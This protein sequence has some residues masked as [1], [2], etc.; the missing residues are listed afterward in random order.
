ML[1]SWVDMFYVSRV[2]TTAVAAVGVSEQIMFFTFSFCLGFAF[3]TSILVARRFGEGN[4]DAAD[5]AATQG[6]VIMFIF[7]TFIAI[8]LYFIYPFLL[9]LMNITGETKR[10]AGIYLSVMVFGL[11]FN[12]L[13]FQMNA[14]VRSIGNSVYPMAI[15]ILSN[16]LN[17][18]IAPMFI[19]G[20]GP[21]PR[22]GVFGAGLGTAIAQFLG[23]VISFILVTRNLTQIKFRWDI[24]FFNRDILAKILRLGIPASL[25]LLAISL[26]RIALSTLANSF[27]EDIL[28]TYML[29]L[30]VDLFVF[31]PIFAVGAAI[32]ITTGQ[33]LGAGKIERIFQYY[34]SAVKQ[35]S[36]VMIAF[37]IIVFFTGNQFAMIFTHKE[38][39]IRSVGE[40]LSIAAI[41]YIFFSIGLISIRVISGAGD[42]IRSLIIVSVVLF[43]F[44][45]PLAWALSSLTGLG[46]YGIW[47]GILIS[48][49]FFSI[50]GFWQLKKKKWLQIDL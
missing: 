29:G 17:A 23:F 25:Q 6:F 31:M 28:T 32:E 41:S 22:L 9:D 8:I 26:N 36:I 11:P 43:A 49:I 42:Y 16:I 48:Q 35:L 24:P 19:F 39:L 37:G 47:Y 34:Y 13:V 2:S 10:L 33:N 12:F 14:I 50:V 20:I 46:Y 4:K 7:S 1:Y 38:P 21:F 45:I 44:Q 3:G 18:I 30:R 5:K 15:L 27:G 40:Y